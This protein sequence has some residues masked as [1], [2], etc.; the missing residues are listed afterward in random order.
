MLPIATAVG[1][2]LVVCCAGDLLVGPARFLDPSA[3][4]Q[5]ALI[6]GLMREVYGDLLEV[7]TYYAVLGKAQVVADR[8]A[9]VLACAW[10]MGCVARVV[11]NSL[12]W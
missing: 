5:L 6:G 2:L 10:C 7:Y 12:P 11:V 4:A 3:P 1:L 8:W 9:T